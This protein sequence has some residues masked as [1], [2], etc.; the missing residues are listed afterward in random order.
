MELNQ[1]YSEIIME[2]YGKSPHRRQ[3]TGQCH[4]QRGHN[5]LCG[6]DLT[7]QVKFQGEIIQDAAFHGVGCAISQASASMLIDLIKG[8]DKREAL[9]LV[10]KFARM[11]KKEAGDYDSLEDA[12][13][14]RGVADFP[15]RVKCALLAWYTLR[16]IIEET[17]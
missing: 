6:D 16:Q 2:H 10:E 14:L 8:K 4:S 11:L 9:V 15:A 5:P 1:L 7:L 12:Q 17:A 13:A 3:L